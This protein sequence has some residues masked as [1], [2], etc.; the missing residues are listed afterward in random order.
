[1]KLNK[2]I[3]TMLS[4]SSVAALLAGC[5]SI[6]CGSHQTLP[7]AS[8]PKDAQVL[9]YDSN[10]NVVFDRTTP[11]TARLKRRTDN[12]E[13]ANYTL[14][15]RKEGFA[16]VQVPLNGTVNRAYLANIAFGGVGLIVDP[17]TGGMWTLHPENLDAKLLDQHAVMFQ[18]DKLFV[19]LKEQVP[20][21]LVSYLE[22]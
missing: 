4:V 18:H 6:I 1:M 13:A 22:P 14:L 5:A 12:F 10:G 8:T 16:P 2:N 11:C 21:D 17:V 9:I 3:I 15:I 19:C 20:S 7:I